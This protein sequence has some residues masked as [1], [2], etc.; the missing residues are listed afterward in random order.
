MARRERMGFVLGS[1]T[2]ACVLSTSQDIRARNPMV[3]VMIDPAFCSEWP[4]MDI[5]QQALEGVSLA[6]LWPMLQSP[7]HS[8][9]E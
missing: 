2:S 8:S 9:T 6:S 5:R 3:N 4:G 7:R 1:F